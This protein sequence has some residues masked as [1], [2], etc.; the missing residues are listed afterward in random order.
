MLLRNAPFVALTAARAISYA[1]DQVA[2][3]ALV[4][5]ISRDHPAT[6]VGGLLLAES[7]PWLLST[8]VASF[9]DRVERRGLMIG[10]QLVQGLIFGAITIWLPPYALLLVLVAS[11][12][13]LGTLLRATTQTALPRIVADEDLM[14]AN[15][16]RGTVLYGA[17][18]LGPAIGGASVG[19][20]GSRAALALDTVTFLISAA[21]LL[22]LPLV[23]P[24]ER[25]DASD[26]GGAMAALRFA[27]RDPLLRSLLLGLTLI[28]AFAG[29]DNVA[30]VFLV[31][32]TLGGGSASYGAAMAVFGAGMVAG[33]ALLV[34][35]RSLRPERMMFGSA[36]VTAAATAALGVAPSLAY[37]YPAQLMG[38]FGNGVENASQSTLIQRL[39][40]PGM[41]GRL[42]GTSQTAVAVGF[43]VSYIGGAA[44]VDATSPRTAFLVA[45]A[46]TLLSLFAL[47]PLLR[48]AGRA[49][50]S[51]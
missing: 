16:V 46:G 31:R 4:L 35:Y 29:V 42:A 34:R 23:P 19:L 36:A 1:G 47:L 39:A 32:D 21:T 51:T 9:A 33:S 10:C 44:L 26:S 17:V 38:G 3:V 8:S 15:A 49:T 30:I 6:A 12:S 28:V 14:P 5:F 7:L 18:I 48:S 24:V 50:P 11:A 37:V 13:L 27:A 25:T 40:P 20:A 22:R 2:A 41:L 43:L 45:G